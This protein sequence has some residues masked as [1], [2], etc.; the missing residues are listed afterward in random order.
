MA[1]R[2]N[3]DPD[4]FLDFVAP[5]VAAYRSAFT[6]EEADVLNL[7][8]KITKVHTGL[9]NLP[10]EEAYKK[11]SGLDPWVQEQ[12]KNTYDLGDA[13]YISKPQNP[14]IRAAKMYGD[15]AVSPFKAMLKVASDYSRLLNFP[16]RALRESGMSPSE[17]L[18]TQASGYTNP[19]AAIGMLGSKLIS[20]SKIRENLFNVKKVW[21]KAWDGRAIFDQ[22]A[23]SKLDEVYEPAERALAVGILEGKDIKEIMSEYGKLDEPFLRSL[24]SLRD[25]GFEKVILEDYRRAQIS[26]GRDIARIVDLRFSEPGIYQQ[27]RAFTALSGSLDAAYQIVIDPLTYLTLGIGNVATKSGRLFEA[28]L[29][30]KMDVEDVF[31]LPEVTKYFDGLG[32]LIQRMIDADDL[33]EIAAARI[34]IARGQYRGFSNDMVLDLL[35]RSRVVDAESAKKFFMA[36]GNAQKLLIGRVDD[37][38]Y[39]RESVPLTSIPYQIAAKARDAVGKFFNGGFDVD[40][41]TINNLTAEIKRLG[42]EAT[43]AEP[44]MPTINSILNGQRKTLRKLA[45]VVANHPAPIRVVLGAGRDEF[46][47]IPAVKETQNQI[48]AYYRLLLENQYLA[49]I[50]TQAFVKAPTV[51][52]R[53][54]AWEGLEVAMAYKLGVHRSEAGREFI[55][56]LRANFSDLTGD[57]SKFRAIQIAQEVTTVAPMPLLKMHELATKNTKAKENILGK[58][59]GGITN[60]RLVKAATDAW[61]VTSLAPQLGIRSAIDEGFFGTLTN[62]YEVIGILASGRADKVQN[63][64]AGMA[65]DEA[66]FGVVKT[67]ILSAL[68]ATPAQRTQKIYNLLKEDDDFVEAVINHFDK[69]GRPGSKLTPRDK[70][71][72]RGRLSDPSYSGAIPEFSYARSL[73]ISNMD[74]APPTEIL[75]KDEFAKSLQSEEMTLSEFVKLEKIYDSVNFSKLSMSQYANFIF[76]FGNPANTRTI[77]V[78]KVD[79]YIDPAGVFIRRNALKDPEDR[80]NAKRDILRSVGVELGD[81]G[82]LRVVKPDLLSRFLST[83]VTADFLRAKGKSNLEIIEGRVNAILDDLYL[84]FHGAIA[85]LRIVGQTGKYTDD[86]VYNEKLYRYIVNQMAKTKKSPLSVVRDIPVDE[87]KKLLKDDEMVFTYKDDKRVRDGVLVNIIPKSF[88][89]SPE[90]KFTEFGNGVMDMMDRTLKDLFRSTAT[91]AWTLFYYQKF[92][93]F[94]KDYFE[95]LLSINVEEDVAKYIARRK[96]SREAEQAAVDRVLK[97]VDNPFVRSNLAYQLRVFSRF[98]RAT[99]DFLRRMYRLSVD[100]PLRSLYRMRLLAL[101]LENAGFVFQNQEN[102][103]YVIVPVDNVIIGATNKIALGLTGKENFMSLPQFSELT[104]KFNTINPSFQAEAGLPLF[105]PPV[106]AIAVRTVSNLLG[107][108]GPDETKIVAQDLDRYLLGEQAGNKRPLFADFQKQTPGLLVPITPAKIYNLFKAPWFFTEDE[109]RNV[110]DANNVMNA[111][112]FLN[113]GGYFPE[114]MVQKVLSGEIS[115]REKNEY[116]KTVRIA[117]HN[118]NVFK[119]MFSFTGVPIGEQGS[120]DLPRSLKEI[121]Y[122]SEN[123]LFGDILAGILALPPDQIPDDPYAVAI[124]TF[125]ADNP[126]RLAYTVTKNE[127]NRITAANVAES[128]DWL[129]KSERYLKAYRLPDEKFAGGAL[130]VFA[131]HMGEF[132]PAAL[133]FQRASGQIENRDLEDFMDDQIAVMWKQ[134]LFDKKDELEEKLGETADPGERARMIRQ[135]QAERDQI[136]Q[137]YPLIADQM[138]NFENSREFKLFMQM[139]QIVTDRTLPEEIITEQQ[140]KKH[141]TVINAIARFQNFAE[142]PAGERSPLYQENK[143][144]AKARIVDE[145]KEL[146]VGD[147][148]MQSAYYNIYLPIINELAR[149]SYRAGPRR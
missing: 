27:D 96:Y 40:Q 5:A 94:E 141:G 1:N 145:I 133:V 48:R 148:S 10:P 39:N 119:T 26:P 92:E 74:D 4:V 87:Y 78:G 105:G 34:E 140:R 71:F 6:D 9:R 84:H 129:I 35:E 117:A 108:I 139:K 33:A 102:E 143:Q 77:S 83:N 53:M 54:R 21:P 63:I 121:G 75:L 73:L 124:A 22:D 29:N 72:I 98:Y 79:H 12:L 43:T 50:M 132:D 123:Q 46:D 24:Q 69:L 20:D 126:G 135:N 42:D 113:A 52:E 115:N 28:V 44:Y 97:F 56:K 2:L 111:L 19:P 130:M 66:S 89:P 107:E 112:A 47:S 114:D 49:E 64:L 59:F 58:F 134:Y 109:N 147:S 88:D 90:N 91:D 65:K 23:V 61:V 137:A 76:R 82:E 13:P 57:E 118:I 101:G 86:Q 70:D 131:P 17:T 93:K 99:E 116:M 14:L 16:Y 15:L 104:L 122:V 8:T 106:G 149:D 55:N 120:L 30:G 138:T 128:V 136:F 95:H 31:K 67:K 41:T 11:Y 32:S 103:N 85:P 110:R 7:F 51:A 146:A 3:L 60:N 142:I 125:V 80:I 62:P 144:A 18:I 68:N 100:T 36:S 38:N 45:T 127:G 81:R 37:I 25:G